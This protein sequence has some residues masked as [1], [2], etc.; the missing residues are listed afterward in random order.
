[1]F[2]HEKYC[3][4]D[5]THYTSLEERINGCEWLITGAYVQDVGD[6]NVLHLISHQSVVVAL[7]RFSHPK[8]KSL[9]LIPHTL[10]AISWL[11]I[12][13]VL[14]LRDLHL[15]YIYQFISKFIN[16]LIVFFL[17]DP[18][19][20]ILKDAFS[21]GLPYTQLTGGSYLLSSNEK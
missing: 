20:E 18:L 10:H 9:M 12:H 14:K 5:W 1:M 13:Q 4:A 17:P 16:R 7:I 21:Q 8:I 2:L 15:L 19:Q 11:L 3:Q 6:Q